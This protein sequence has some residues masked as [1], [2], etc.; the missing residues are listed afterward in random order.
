MAG[1]GDPTMRGVG[2][3]VQGGAREGQN[4]LKG[5]AV[6]LEVGSPSRITCNPKAEAH[7][8]HE[9]SPVRVCS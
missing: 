1:G 8:C 9:A 4:L 7:C 2:T 6:G 3:S 5:V